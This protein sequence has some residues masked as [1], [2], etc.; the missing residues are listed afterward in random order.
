MPPSSSEETTFD[1]VL[2]PPPALN[3]LVTVI[4]NS[5]Y[6]TSLGIAVGKVVIDSGHRTI[7]WIP[8][9]NLCTYNTLIGISKNFWYYDSESATI[10]LPDNANIDKIYWNAYS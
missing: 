1:V 5:T 10:S 6:L 3:S 8:D 4:A 2:T 7:S 9:S